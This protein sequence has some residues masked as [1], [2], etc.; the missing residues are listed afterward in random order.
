MYKIARRMELVSQMDITTR[1][2][3]TNFQTTNYGLGGTC[4]LHVDPYGYIEGVEIGESHQSLIDSGDMLAT[5]MGW[6]EDTDAGGGTAF[7]AP[8]KEFLVTPR[9]GAVAFWHDLDR[10]GYRLNEAYHGG[11]PVLKG[12]KWIL[13]KWIYYFNQFQKFPC[14]LNSSQKYDSPKGYFK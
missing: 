13:N 3:S 4:D 8:Y 10:K 12:S 2:S 6:L 1:H 11:C 14:G 7:L 9:K 5:F